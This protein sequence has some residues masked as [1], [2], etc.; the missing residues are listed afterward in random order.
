MVEVLAIVM[1]LEWLLPSIEV[2]SVLVEM[3][4]ILLLRIGMLWKAP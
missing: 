3:E 4:R 2:A 1:R